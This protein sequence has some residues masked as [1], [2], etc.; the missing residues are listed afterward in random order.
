MEKSRKSRVK[1][2]LK[3]HKHEIFII[4]FLQKPNPYGPKGM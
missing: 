2:P 1:L 4:T 3:V